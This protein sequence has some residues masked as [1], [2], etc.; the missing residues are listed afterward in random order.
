MSPP[1]SVTTFCTSTTVSSPLHWRRNLNLWFIIRFVN[2][3][4]GGTWT[5]RAQRH[6]IYSAAR[7]QLRYT[8]PIT[9]LPY[10]LLPLL[11]GVLVKILRCENSYYQT[12]PIVT[13]STS[14]KYVYFSLILTRRNLTAPI[15]LEGIVLILIKI[16]HSLLRLSIIRLG[17]IS[18]NCI[19]CAQDS[20][21]LTLL[22][23]LHLHRTLTWCLSSFLHRSRRRAQF[24]L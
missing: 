4:R 1:I 21:L 14:N 19:G 11:W 5:P 2:C 7:Y 8:L 3:G 6:R 22:T 9:Y 23:N 12:S 20:K 18:V 15:P 17:Y 10:T 16:A 24:K 13:P